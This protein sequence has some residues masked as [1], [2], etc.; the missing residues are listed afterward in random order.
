VI[1]KIKHL[2]QRGVTNGSRI[3]RDAFITEAR[4]LVLIFSAI[5]SKSE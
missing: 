2:P 1:L 5:I 4:E 3:I